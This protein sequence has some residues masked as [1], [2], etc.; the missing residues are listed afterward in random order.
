MSNV[1]DKILPGLREVRTP[2]VC[3]YFWLAFVGVLTAPHLRAH[4]DSALAHDI[5]D[6]RNLGVGTAGWLAVLSVLAYLVGATWE[7][8]GW[9]AGKYLYDRLRGSENPAGNSWVRLPWCRSEQSR[10]LETWIRDDASKA[11]LEADDE[12]V[13]KRLFEVLR[14]LGTAPT[15]MIGAQPALWGEWDRLDAEGRFRMTVSVP[16]AAAGIAVGFALSPTAG[17]WSVAGSMVALVVLF[18]LGLTKGR[19]ATEVLLQA[20]DAG[21]L[22]NLRA[23]P[24]IDFVDRSGP[25]SHCDRT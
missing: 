10:R 1:L 16:L 23:L 14:E 4:G 20:L 6:L 24:H 25:Q 13:R 7:G 17:W 8:V 2:L 15:K 11:G 18:A 3:G 21:Q 22:G 12:Y 5:A 19:D 9:V